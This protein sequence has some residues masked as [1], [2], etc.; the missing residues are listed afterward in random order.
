MDILGKNLFIRCVI[1]GV[2]AFFAVTKSILIF[3]LNY[4]ADIFN[5]LIMS[6]SFWIGRPWY[7]ENARGFDSYL[8]NNFLVPL[9]GPVTLICGV[10][11]II[12]II[13]L[14]LLWASIKIELLAK[15][16]QNDK[17]R[18]LR[19]ILFIL[20]LGPIT[21]WIFDNP[22]YGFHPEVLY[23]PL[24]A[25]YVC[26]RI[27]NYKIAYIIAALICLVRQDGAVVLWVVEMFNQLI[28]CDSN[29]SESDN[30]STIYNVILCSLVCGIIFLSGLWILSIFGT[31]GSQRVTFAISQI[32][33]L[34]TDPEF[35]TAVL[36]MILDSIVLVASGLV[37]FVLVAPKKVLSC[38]IFIIPV[39]AVSVL[40]SFAYL[41][42]LKVMLDHGTT[43]APRAAIIWSLIPAL[44]ILVVTKQSNLNQISKKYRL[45]AVSLFLSLA[46]QGYFLTTKVNY[47][48]LS[49]IYNVYTGNL[50]IN[51]L[52]ERENNFLSCISKNIPASTTVATHGSLAALFHRHDIVFT[53]SIS[54][55]YKRPEL[56]VCESNNRLPWEYDCN[57]SYE[58]YKQDES[59][60]T[61]TVEG[62]K[63]ASQ[64]QHKSVL[65]KCFLNK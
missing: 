47:H 16:V 48:L 24:V 63:A 29:N 23:I 34:P 15:S 59:I 7:F 45:I 53:N 26:Y 41:P 12:L 6:K 50:L 64:P 5:F 17:A 38:L 57:Q 3:G 1:F 33:T 30:R 61:V 37:L 20:L 65:R 11:G 36:K 35:S 27:N 40:S 44:G 28:R 25:L 52:S 60:F 46:L 42:N 14:L 22:V 8:H 56:I 10:Y 49:Q 4:T 2:V 21:F 19:L 62:I 31:P 32:R 18:W 39:I 58:K 13:C 9:M 55:A 51:F 43:W 54:N